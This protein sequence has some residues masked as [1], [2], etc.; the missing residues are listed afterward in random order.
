MGRGSSSSGIAMRWKRVDEEED[1]E[2]QDGQ[3]SG[4]PEMTP[5][6]R[7]FRKYTKDDKEGKRDGDVS[8]GGRKVGEVED[9]AWHRTNKKE[10]FEEMVATSVRAFVGL[11]YQEQV[12]GVDRCFQQERA[13]EE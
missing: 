8:G 9:K 5:I 2:G 3:G 11:I 4:R 6:A 1:E 13:L 12:S 10:S 7:R